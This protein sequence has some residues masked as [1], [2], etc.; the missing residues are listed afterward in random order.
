MITSSPL[1]RYVLWFHSAVPAKGADAQK[2]E[3]MAA[4]NSL[5]YYFN[6]EIMNRIYNDSLLDPESLDY[7]KMHLEVS[8]AVSP[9]LISTSG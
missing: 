2:P 8:N 1:I 5:A 3:K 7:K 9:L 6:I 4:P